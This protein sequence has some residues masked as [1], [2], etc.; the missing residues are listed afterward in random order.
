MHNEIGQELLTDPP[1]K[2]EAETEDAGI[3][4]SFV[5]ALIKGYPE[6]VV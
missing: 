2:P 6:N 3:F 1:S 4:L 5:K